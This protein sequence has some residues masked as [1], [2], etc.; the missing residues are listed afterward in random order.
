MAKAF[1]LWWNSSAFKTVAFSDLLLPF[2]ARFAQV[3]PDIELPAV[4]LEF[5]DLLLV[6]IEM[7][8][9]L[10]RTGPRMH[11]TDVQDLLAEHLGELRRVRRMQHGEINISIGPFRGFFDLGHRVLLCS[12]WCGRAAVARRDSKGVSAAMPG[13]V[14]VRRRN[15]WPGPGR[16]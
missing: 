9:D 8:F 4:L 7:N 3:L 15:T 11:R 5:F 10:L 16:T 13:G 12:F 14:S 2:S 1:W 6:G